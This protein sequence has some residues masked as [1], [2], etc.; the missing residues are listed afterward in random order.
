MSLNTTIGVITDVNDYLSR[1]SEERLQIFLDTII[2]IN[3]APDYRFDFSTINKKVDNYGA[4]LHMLD[5]LH[6][7]T[8][9]E[10]QQFFID[11]PKLLKYIPILLGIR[12]DKMKNGVLSV[13]DVKGDYD[14]DFTNIDI[15]KIDYYVKFIEDSGLYNVLK[16]SGIYRSVHDYTYGVEA[17]LNSNE[18]KNRSG[19]EGESH[20]AMILNSIVDKYPDAP[21]Y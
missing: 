14:L 20:L 10:M 16:G 17:G 5:W 19:N 2:D 7:K 9:D 11:N 8:I 13:F 4:E 12:D 15:S 18:R 21:S 6:D 3:H 1:S